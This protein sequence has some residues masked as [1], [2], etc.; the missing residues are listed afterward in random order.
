VYL[1]L[2]VS[3]LVF[4]KISRKRKVAMREMAMAT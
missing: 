1:I 3:D 4:P 2:S